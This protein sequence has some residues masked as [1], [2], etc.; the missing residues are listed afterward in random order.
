ME[1]WSAAATCD[2][3]ESNLEGCGEKIHIM[4]RVRGLLGSMSVTGGAI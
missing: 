4:A 1:G 2:E 3:A